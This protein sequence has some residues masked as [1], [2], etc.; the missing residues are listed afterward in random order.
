M[1]KTLWD[2]YLFVGVFISAR[3]LVHALFLWLEIKRKRKEKETKAVDSNCKHRNVDTMQMEDEKGIFYQNI[4]M[5]CGKEWEHRP[6]HTQT[7]VYTKA[8]NSRKKRVS[9]RSWKAL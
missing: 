5:D 1:N 3:M 4:C 7:K 6:I 8:N 2:I 9:S